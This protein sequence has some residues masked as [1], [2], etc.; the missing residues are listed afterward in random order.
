MRSVIFGLAMVLALL[1][2]AGAH[3]LQDPTRPPDAR[4]ASVQNE[5][6]RDI[7]L[8]SIL[9]GSQRRVAV[10]NGVALREGDDHD[11]IRVRR[12]HRD[13]VDV[14]D[15]GQPRVL[16]PPTLPQVRITQ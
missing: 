12:I 5:A 4:P 15:R 14:T 9:L 7:E 8:G 2:S 11:G 13:K 16:Y 6:P 10:I 3:A 1:A